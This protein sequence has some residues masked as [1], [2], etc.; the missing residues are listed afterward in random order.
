ME[1]AHEASKL[2]AAGLTVVGGIAA[3]QNIDTMIKG[4]PVLEP[5][6]D[7]I[8]TVLAGGL[9]G[10]ATALIVYAID[11][12]DFFN[13]EKKKNHAL[14]MGRLEAN[15]EKMFAEGE[16]LISDMSFSV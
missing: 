4:F 1:A 13:V 5:F 16:A 11:R 15:M 6:A 9:T 10:L 7:L 8:T 2:I 3:E 14:V 12:M